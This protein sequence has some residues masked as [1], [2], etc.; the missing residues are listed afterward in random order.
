MSLP[1]CPSAGA[2]QRSRRSQAAKSPPGNG[3]L[4]RN[5]VAPENGCRKMGCRPVAA[6]RSHASRAPEN[7]FANQNPPA[8]FEILTKP[9]KTDTIKTLKK[10]F[11]LLL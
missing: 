10:E 1:F 9:S 5:S 4:L 8:L 6:Q 2:A 3:V 7:G 11:R